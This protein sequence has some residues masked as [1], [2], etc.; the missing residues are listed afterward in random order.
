MAEKEADT[1]AIPEKRS[2]SLTL[3]V[4]IL[5]T[6][7]SVRERAS[8]EVAMKELSVGPNDEVEPETLFEIG[9]AQGLT[10]EE[11]EIVLRK[12]APT[13]EEQSADAN[14]HG[15]VATPNIEMREL[16]RVLMGVFGEMYPALKIVSQFSPEDSYNPGAGLYYYI[17]KN[18]V[19]PK[20]FKSVRGF[21]GM[22]ENETSAKNFLVLRLVNYNGRKT[23]EIHD[24]RITAIAG[25]IL[26]KAGFK[27]SRVYTI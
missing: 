21:L 22:S 6:A 12:L 16:D 2:V 10:R 13:K 3:G 17:V 11:I 25:D 26:Q 8:F 20:R 24:P 18:V 27:M 15:L 5:Q 9:Q 14:E 23:G 7:E 1:L 19:T 4:K